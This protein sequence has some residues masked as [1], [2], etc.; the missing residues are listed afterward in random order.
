MSVL[1]QWPTSLIQLHMTCCICSLPPLQ[2]VV[3]GDQG[4]PAALAGAGPVKQAPAQDSSSRQLLALEGPT[5]I[6][7][8]GGG[9]GSTQM[10]QT[11]QVPSAVVMNAS[12]DAGVLDDEVDG[13]EAEAAATAEVGWHGGMLWRSRGPA[14]CLCWQADACRIPAATSL[15]LAS[16]IHRHGITSWAPANP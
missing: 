9:R 13:A 11:Q 10:Q 15:W 8:S 3:K 16:R 14:R 1:V 4:A 6:S 5:A 12:S 7:S 2:A